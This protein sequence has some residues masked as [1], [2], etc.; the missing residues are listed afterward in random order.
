MTQIQRS[1]EVEMTFQA[2]SKNNVSKDKKTN[3]KDASG[4][5]GIDQKGIQQ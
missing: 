3:V 5:D 4:K 2:M 1:R